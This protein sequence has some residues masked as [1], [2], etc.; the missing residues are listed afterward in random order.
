MPGRVACMRA[1]NSASSLFGATSQDSI[2]LHLVVGQ[3]FRLAHG[4]GERLLPIRRQLDKCCSYLAS[5]IVLINRR[6][7]N[8]TPMNLKR[9][10]RGA[11]PRFDVLTT[12]MDSCVDWRDKR[13]GVDESYRGL[14]GLDRRRARPSLRGVSRRAGA[15]RE[16]LA[17]LRTRTDQAGKTRSRDGRLATPLDAPVRGWRAFRR[18]TQLSFPRSYP[19]VQFP[20]APLV[21]A[22]IS[23]LVAHYAQGQAHSNAQAVSYLSMA[24]WAY[25]ELFQGV[26]AFRRLLGLTYTIST[27]I[28]LA[29]A[30]HH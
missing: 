22:F 28:H 5:S 16:R 6:A 11:A 30:L 27:A 20:N 29:T 4:V 12:L 21:L 19:I 9:S 18:L 7:R 2:L 1:S 13:R 10:R 17:R 8:E 26:N 14:D 25:L 15:G 24:V 23:G 3:G